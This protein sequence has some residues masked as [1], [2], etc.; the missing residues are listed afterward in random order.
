VHE[1]HYTGQ[2][3]GMAVHPT[4]PDLFVTTGDDKTIRVWS[5]SGR[6]LLR[7][8]LI[9]CTARSVAFSP[10][11]STILVGM[12]GLEDG[13][14]QRKDGSFLLL[15][16]HTMKPIFE[17]RDSRHWL[18]DV[19]YSPDNQSFALGSMDHKIY[20]YNAETFRLKGTCDRHN[21]AI[22]DFDFSADGVYIQ[23]DSSDY[24]HLYFEAEDG[25]FFSAGSQLK[26]IK[27]SQWTCKFG[28]PMQGAWPFFD[29]VEKGVAF[30]PSAV[31]RSPN[32]QLLAVGDKSGAVKLM[33]YPA[34][35]KDAP[36]ASEPGHVNP[37][38]KVRFSCDGRYLLSMGKSDRCIIIWK[39]LPQ[40]STDT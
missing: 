23:S 31:H 5:I 21:G 6:R 26:D 11:G 25:S 15:D 34:I 18:S 24:E 8:A 16:A 20:L 40:A 4:D 1:A 39:V 19:K 29:K 2:L 36:V 32:N 28:W 37:V 3:W 22:A 30:E 12:G 33:N 17:G 27:W 38:A 35:S 14:R 9:D 10:D 13:K 7:K